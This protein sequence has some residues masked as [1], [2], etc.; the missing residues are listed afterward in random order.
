MANASSIGKQFIITLLIL[1]IITTTFCLTK[2]ADACNVTIYGEIKILSENGKTELNAI[3][4]QL[5]TPGKQETQ[6]KS[7]IITNM[8]KQPVYIR[9]AIAKSSIAW[10]SGLK[11]T[12]P[13][14]AHTQDG[15]QKYTLRI[16]QTARGH[17]KCLQPTEAVIFLKDKED[18]RLTLE[19][20]YSGKPSTPET[21]TLTL[22]F[23]A[24][25]T[26]R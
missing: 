22:T 19:L 18:V 16:V 25:G 5:F 14:Y 24:I 11:Q 7:F 13:G 1:T 6:H 15:I 17:S 23:I 9:W 12:Q 8:G 21:F 4:F 20:T 26:G 10:N 2:Q 3:K